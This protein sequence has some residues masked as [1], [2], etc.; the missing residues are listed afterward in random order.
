MGV[1]DVHLPTALVWRLDGGNLRAV[2]CSPRTN[3]VRIAGQLALS[4]DAVGLFGMYEYRHL[5]V[6]EDCA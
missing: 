4:F 6:V 1:E 3:A 5:E 2:R